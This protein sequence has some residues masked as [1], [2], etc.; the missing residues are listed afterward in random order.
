MHTHVYTHMHTHTHAHSF[1]G[2]T[3]TVRQEVRRKE[4]LTMGKCSFRSFQSTRWNVNKGERV[5]VHITCR[6]ELGTTQRVLE[7]FW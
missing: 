2:G 3:M 5:Q 7:P 1:S 4:G 6:W